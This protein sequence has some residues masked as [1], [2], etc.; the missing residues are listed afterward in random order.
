MFDHLNAA[1]PLLTSLVSSPPDFVTKDGSLKN[2]IVEYYVYTA[3][4]SLISIDP[5]PT[6]IIFLTPDLTSQAHKLV[7]SSYI[8]QLCGCWLELLLLIPRIFDFGRRSLA[9]ES[10]AT[11]PPFPTADDF[12][13]FSAL[14]M[15]ILGF[16]TYLLGLA[17]GSDVALC[18]QIFQ[19]AV[20]LYLLTCLPSSRDSDGPQKTA[21]NA[22]IGHAFEFL[23][24]L[25][26]LSRINTSLCWALAVV[27]S[28]ISDAKLQAELRQ[29]LS[30]MFGVIGLGNIQA[31]AAV[32]ERVWELPA[33]Q[34]SPWV[35]C[36]VMQEHEIWISFA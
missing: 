7:E 30:T 33:E 22:A 2:F 23:R 10:S 16:N 35:I 15:Q 6:T 9:S 11:N 24:Q 28:C 27:G 34:R 25:S 20:H 17:P 13:T 29:R 19:Q 36:K 8:G 5:R 31:T 32:L 26:P 18:G 4:I 21:V 14:Q 12:A 3:S 1:G